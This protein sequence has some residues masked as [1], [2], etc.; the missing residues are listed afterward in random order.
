[1]IHEIADAKPVDDFHIGEAYMYGRGV[2][3]DEKRASRSF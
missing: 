2:P 3:Q 1:M